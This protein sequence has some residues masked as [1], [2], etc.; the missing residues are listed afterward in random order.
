MQIGRRLSNIVRNSTIKK[1]VVAYLPWL[2]IYGIIIKGLELGKSIPVAHT[3][4]EAIQ[5]M[6]SLYLKGLKNK[7]KN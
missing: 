2:A 4:E 3:V 7:K 1:P 6:H 5:M